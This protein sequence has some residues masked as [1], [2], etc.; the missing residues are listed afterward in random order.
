MTSAMA[1]DWAAVADSGAAPLNTNA[2]RLNDGRVLYGV[3]LYEPSTGLWSPTSGTGSGYL[4]TETLLDDG[5]VLKVGH[6]DLFWFGALPYAQLYDPN[7]NTWSDTTDSNYGH[8]GHLA[9]KLADGRVLIAGISRDGGT[10]AEIFDP[11]TE[12]WTVTGN[13]NQEH[14]HGFIQLL[15]NGKVMVGGGTA[16]YGNTATGIELYDPVTGSWTLQPNPPGLWR[17]PASVR[18]TNGRIL[19]AA[20][21]HSYLYDPAS[22]SWTAAAD[23]NVDHGG[24]FLLTLLDDGQ[25]LIAGGFDNIGYYVGGKA[26]EVYNPLTDSWTRISDMPENRANYG[27]ALLQNGH[28]LLAG[29]SH[30]DPTCCD[31]Y[32]AVLYT[33]PGSPEP[34][35][36][37]PPPPPPAPTPIHISDIDNVSGGGTLQWVPE[38]KF[39]IVDN[40][41]SPVGGALVTGEWSNGLSGTASCSTINDGTCSIVNLSYPKIADVPD[42]VFTVTDVV[43]T[44]MVY[45]A[46]ANSDPDGD[47]DGTSIIVYAPTTPPP[48]PTPS[49]M[50][51]SDL[52]GIS[53]SISRRS[54]QA[55]TTIT[56]L[57]DLGG[58][59]ANAIVEGVWTGGYSNTS[60]CT[61]D[62]NGMCS[63]VTGNIRN[64]NS[65]TTFTVSNISHASLNYDA[66]TNSDIDLDSNG[67]SI[68]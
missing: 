31:V 42:P 62:N 29:G 39:T 20:E 35:V 17:Y 14:V 27:A 26:A 65:S 25:V 6:Y 52:D 30:T 49:T 5:R 24:G 23:L 33:P 34:P 68:T 11:A 21:S 13:M 51:V 7:T 15:D 57:D 37:P 43:R 10:V 67:T 19:V 36:L 32:S 45:D 48:V 8:G 44:D 1:A 64:K 28:V 9:V 16:D 40:N 55:T 60:N 61:T 4:S 58:T 56:V 66:A 3:R 59:V 50:S 54:W 22:N 2:V 38:V 18:L 53:V 47:S 41:N 46:V 63:V 12:T